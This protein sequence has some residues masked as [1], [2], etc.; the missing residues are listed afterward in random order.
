MTKLLNLYLRICSHKVAQ[1]KCDLDLQQAG[2][3][4]LSKLK[5]VTNVDYARK[6]FMTAAVPMILITV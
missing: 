1:F 2:L 5:F 4:L 3:M 6:S